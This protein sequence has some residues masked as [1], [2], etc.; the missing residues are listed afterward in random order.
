MIIQLNLKEIPNSFEQLCKSQLSALATLIT[1]VSEM[2]VESG[3]KYNI[4]ERN[5]NDN[6]HRKPSRLLRIL[7]I[8]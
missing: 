8:C 3:D 4:I 5:E 6:N 2:M 7:H 1:T